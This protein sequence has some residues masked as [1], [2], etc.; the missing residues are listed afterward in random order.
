MARQSWLDE[1]TGAPMIDQ[2]A[3]RLTSFLDSVADGEVDDDEL[4]RKAL[5]T[6][7]LSGIARELEARGLVTSAQHGDMLA[8]QR[9][10]LKRESPD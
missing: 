7:R 6:D 8:P 1:T 10:V 3:R 5:R 2:Y 4:V 9:A